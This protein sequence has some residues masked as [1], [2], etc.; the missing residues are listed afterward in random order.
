[1]E[2]R[3]AAAVLRQIKLQSEM[4]EQLFPWERLAQNLQIQSVSQA[5]RSTIHAKQTEK[6][7][8]AVDSVAFDIQLI[9]IDNL[10]IRQRALLLKVFNQS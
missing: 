8:K 2:A 3:S 1:M 9:A 6:S 4:E 5:I 7:D 10:L